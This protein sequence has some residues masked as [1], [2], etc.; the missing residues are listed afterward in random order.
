MRLV[1]ICYDLLNVKAPPEKQS[2]PLSCYN[3][4]YG[5]WTPVEEV[6]EKIRS[7]LDIFIVREWKIYFRCVS[8]K[9]YL[10]RDALIPVKNDLNKK[11]TPFS[12]LTS[13]Y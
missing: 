4:I 11:N 5:L 13:E 10:G 6:L 1:E 3:S 9:L 7:R 2:A 8:F 12:F